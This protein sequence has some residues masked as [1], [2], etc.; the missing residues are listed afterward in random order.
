MDPRGMLG[1]DNSE[2][3][4]LPLCRFLANKSLTD[5]EDKDFSGS[6]MTD[7]SLQLMDSNL[8][9]AQLAMGSLAVTSVTPTDGS[10]SSKAS[11]HQEGFQW[12]K[13]IIPMICSVGIV[14]NLLNLVVLTRRRMLSSMQRLERCAT[15]GLTSLAM[16]DMMLCIVVLP[17][18]FIT[19]RASMDNSPRVIFSIYYRV[20]GI[21]LI[22]LFMMVSNW[23]TVVIAINRFLVV[24]YPIHA[25]HFLSSCKTLASILT[26]ALLSVT[27]SSPYFMH[28]HVAP[29]ATPDG[30]SLQELKS[31]FPGI[32][33]ELRMYIR[34]IWP[35]LAV[36]IPLFI[37]AL[38]N[39]CLIRELNRAS[40]YR[41]N[42]CRRTKVK[43]TSHKVTLTLVIIV[44]MVFLLV[45][46][47]EILKYI[48]PYKSWGRVGHMVA[49]VTNVLQAT[50]FAVNFFLYCV[51]N[52][53]FRRT[54]SDTFLHCRHGQSKNSLDN[55]RIVNG[56]HGDA[57]VRSSLLA[58]EETC[59][60]PS[61]Q[62]ILTNSDS[63]ILI[64]EFQSP[65]TA[66]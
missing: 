51:V 62:Q 40:L 24:M 11:L 6:N 60:K 44:L 19:A 39:A 28:L 1:K 46:P 18:T 53:N 64:K 34:W 17:H 13:I 16:S 29:C 37:L 10:T 45:S 43:D 58:L 2:H 41:R 27:L 54:I 56:H 33:Q 22:N 50:N 32:Q 26:V 52:P 3:A 61:Q 5:P 47:S 65:L 57:T 66:L 42:S 49:S 4:P 48:N 14:G 63:T 25:R 21:A 9:H 7:F 23:L 36:F 35:I 38:C 20:Y 15:Y 31:S 59:R 12:F 30:A 55:S 8:T